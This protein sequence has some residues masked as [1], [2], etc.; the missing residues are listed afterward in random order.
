MRIHVWN[1]FASNNSGSYTIVGR[2]AKEEVAARVAAELKEV[3]EAHGVWWETA[4][5]EMKKDHERPSPLDLFIQKHGLTGGADIGSYED[6]PTSSGKSAPDAWAIGHQVFVHHPFTITLPR[7][8]GEFIYAQGGRVETELEHSHHPVVSVFEFWRGEHGQEDVE[9]R[10]VALL[11][12]L[13]VEDGPL[14]T[15]IDWDVLPAWKLSGGFGGPLLR[16]G[17]VFEDL[18][19]GFTAVERIARGYNLHVSVKVF[20]A[21]PD[22]DPLAFLRPNEPLLKRERFDVWLT[23]LGDKPEEVKRLL[24]DERPLTY[25]EVCALQGAEP[26]VVWKWRPPAQAEELASRL[27]RAGASVEVRPTPVT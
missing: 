2:F 12:E 16:M 24:R 4:Y 14:V 25:E 8:L 10:L 19:T 17:A 18:A 20:E 15:G 9:R 11:E 13:N 7:T 23:D 26:I 1:A 27:R 5:S 6:W 21:W 22:A 3:L